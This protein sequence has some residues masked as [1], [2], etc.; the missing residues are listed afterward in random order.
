M[1]SPRITVKTLKLILN[2]VDNISD[3]REPTKY[4]KL[5]DVLKAPSK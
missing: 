1:A 3:I 5:I 2:S 4:K